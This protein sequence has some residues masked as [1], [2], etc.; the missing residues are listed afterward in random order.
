MICTLSQVIKSFMNF[1]ESKGNSCTMWHKNSP[2]MY[3]LP[4]NEL[5]VCFL[6]SSWKIKF[7]SLQKGS[8]MSYGCEIFFAGLHRPE[9][10]TPSK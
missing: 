5:S 2:R 8:K 10:I 7:S 1:S 6:N 3:L 9:A 4:I